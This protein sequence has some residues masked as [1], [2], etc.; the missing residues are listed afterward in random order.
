MPSGRASADTYPPGSSKG[1][2][3]LVYS[4]STLPPALDTTS[5]APATSSLAQP[6]IAA[7]DSL[8]FF[9]AM[10][11]FAFHIYGQYVGAGG[12]DQAWRYGRTLIFGGAVW[13]SFFFVLSGFVLTLAYLDAEGTFRSG[14]RKYFVARLARIY[15]IH[16]LVLAILVLV[17][18]V[19]TPKLAMKN[20]PSMLTHATLTQ[21]WVPPH[22]R[23]WNVPSWSLSCEM[24]FYAVL[25]LLGPALMRVRTAS[26]LKLIAAAAWLVGLSFAAIYIMANPEGFGAANPLG[27]QEDQ[28]WLNAV[29][30][31]PLTRLPEFVLGI[32]A[33]GLLH[34][35]RAAVAAGERA[36]VTSEEAMRM[37]ALGLTGM[38][39]SIALSDTIPY[40]MIHMTFAAPFGALAIYGLAA[41]RHPLGDALAYRPLAIL[42]TAG[43]GIYLLHVPMLMLLELLERSRVISGS[44]LQYLLLVP[45]TVALALV[46][47][48]GFE[49][50]V[51]EWIRARFG[52]AGSQ[53][54]GKER[55]RPVPTA[56]AVAEPGG[57]E[58]GPT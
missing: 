49:R 4:R 38:A 22:V 7:L 40:I 9:G 31:G 23:K 51:G 14:M 34:R 42:G 3:R 5:R 11:V 30:F 16:G 27:E 56:G 25:P 45:V 2:G 8:R 48:R 1:H 53:D 47:N 19:L 36:P 37:T 15:P 20:V 55:R 28:F 41:A 46:V 32:C 33:G 10:H 24:F 50:P 18:F 57:P 43:L 13:L 58:G 26:R 21:A 35:R 29:T 54:Q 52:R 17:T 6:K 44:L 39:V 12:F